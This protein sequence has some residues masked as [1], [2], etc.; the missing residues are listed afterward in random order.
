MV[1]VD[2]RDGSVQMLYPDGWTQ[3]LGQ[4][5]PLEGAAICLQMKDSLTAVDPVSGRVLWTRSD[6]S[7]RSRLFGDDQYVF[8][9]EM[10]S[11]VKSMPVSTRVFR[12]YDGATVKAPDFH[13]LYNPER[14][15]CL[16][17][18]D[19]VVADQDKDATTLRLYDPLTGNDV[20]KQAFAPKSLVLR[21]EGDDLA[22]VVE[23]SGRVRVV[24][25]TTRKE[26]LNATSR[27]VD[28]KYLGKEAVLTVLGD[29]S[30]VYVVCDDPVDAGVH[31]NTNLLPGT[32]LRGLNVNGK[33]YAFP[34][35]GRAVLGRN[36]A[37]HPVGVGSVPGDAD[38]VANGPYGKARTYRHVD[39]NVV[40]SSYREA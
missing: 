11:D 7:P 39:P 37:L 35:S 9:V 10:S 18:R 40:A 26:V 5:G 22:G 30:H 3:Q 17:G 16:V 38:A 12:L 23:P 19:I 6:V 2:P 8:V 34:R 31:V 14:R 27:K 1:T 29:A 32:G 24:D 15:I 25:L 13:E 21:T 20:W 33:I 28:P 36:G 4:T